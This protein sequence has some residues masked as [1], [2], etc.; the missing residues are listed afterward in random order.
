[1][2]QFYQPDLTQDVDDPFARDE[3]GRLIRR[4]YWQDLG[5]RSLILALINGVGA[6]LTNEQ[7]KTH[8][9]DLSRGHLID[10]IGVQEILPPE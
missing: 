5:D 2:T 8:L 9:I 6:Q 3:T 7:K 10:Q 1:M 4:S